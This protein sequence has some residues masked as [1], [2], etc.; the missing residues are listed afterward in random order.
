MVRFA[1]SRRPDWKPIALF[2][3]SKRFIGRQNSKQRIKGG[4]LFI[5][6]KEVGPLNND[7]NLTQEGETIARAL[8]QQG[9]TA[10]KLESQLAWGVCQTDEDWW[11]L[12]T[13]VPRPV[14]QWRLL[15]ALHDDHQTKLYSII[16]QTICA[17]SD[18]QG[19]SRPAKA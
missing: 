9:Y 17:V 6:A 1:R 13:F 12:L 7:P 10:Q 3:N 14:A 4:T 15:P 18:S 8:M 5:V 11:M 16:E 19:G 2:D